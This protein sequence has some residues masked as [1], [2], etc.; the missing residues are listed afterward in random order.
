M[1]YSIKDAFKSLEQLE[2]ETKLA[3][4]SKLT[5]DFKVGDKIKIVNMQGEPQYTGKKGEITHIDDLGQLH[6]TWGGVAIIPEEDD[7]EIIEEDIKDK[8]PQTAKKVDG[9]YEIDDFGKK[10]LLKNYTKKDV[11]KL[12]FKVDEMYEP[13]Y[14]FKTLKFTDKTSNGLDIIKIFRDLHDDRVHVIAYEPEVKDYV[15]G[16][17]YSFDSGS[18]NQGWY[19]F[20]S[21]KDAVKELNRR[22]NVEE[23]TIDEIKDKIEKPLE[24]DTV[25]KGDKWVNKGKEGTHG[26]FKTKKEADAQRKAMFAKK[27]VSEARGVGKGQSL[28]K[29]FKIVNNYN[30]PY[31]QVKEE[32][33]DL[34]LKIK[35]EI[36]RYVPKSAY[37]ERD[38]ENLLNIIEHII[39]ESKYGSSN[40][41]IDI[42]EAKDSKLEKEGIQYFGTKNQFNYDKLQL[43]IDHDNKTYQL[44]AFTHIAKR[45]TVSGPEL[46]RI[47]KRLEDAGYK[48]ISDVEEDLSVSKHMD[49]I[50]FIEKTIKDTKDVLNEE[51]EVVSYFDLDNTLSVIFVWEDGY[52]KNNPN[53]IYS[54]DGEYVLTAGVGVYKEDAGG[55][56]YIIPYNPDSYEVYDDFNAV[57]TDDTPR[58]L[59]N[60]LLQQYNDI[61]NT[62]DVK[63]DGKL[64]PKEVEETEDDKIAYSSIKENKR[65][66]L[67][68]IKKTYLEED[69]ESE[70]KAYLDW[71]KEN[72]K[73]ASNGKVFLDYCQKF[74]IGKSKDSSKEDDLEEGH[75]NSKYSLSEIKDAVEYAFGL[76][77]KERDDYIKNTSTETLDALVDDFKANAKKSFFADSLKKDCKNKVDDTNLSEENNDEKCNDMKSCLDRAVKQLASTKESLNQD[78]KKPLKENIGNYKIILSPRANSRGEFC[79]RVYE[80]LKIDINKSFYTKD[81]N[82]A[83]EQFKQISAKLKQALNEGEHHFKCCICGKEV[84]GWGNN[85]WPVKEEGECCDDCNSNEVIPARIFQIYKNLNP[86][87]EIKEDT[88]TGYI[89]NAKIVDKLPKVGDLYDDNPDHNRQNYYVI[90]INDKGTKDGYRI[91]DIVGQDKEDTDKNLG[92]NIDV[93]HYSVAIKE[94]LKEDKQFSLRDANG[95]E[96]AKNYLNTKKEDELEQ[97]VDVDADNPE[98]LKTSYIGDILLRCRDCRTVKFENPEDVVKDENS[99]STEETQQ[100]TLYNVGEECPHCGSTKGYTIAGQVVVADMNLTQQD[101]ET[102][103]STPTDTAPADSTPT[104]QQVE[105][106][107]STEVEDEIIDD[108]I[109]DSEE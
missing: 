18:W 3:K 73:D 27:R 78:N 93:L 108:E 23:I 16:L 40:E 64:Y 46:R 14:S 67:K 43:R 86:K 49:L 61:I 29:Y 56:Y 71:C 36:I 66:G 19:D 63:K 101:E 89:G 15:V 69:I 22:Y 13:I 30:D 90:K 99:T 103:D 32:D 95:V 10:K 88:S 7:I 4:S 52:E 70:I 94:C 85:P 106:E 35:T 65:V 38:K 21:V 2:E 96:E 28:D 5:E 92:D 104:K 84:D 24:E 105:N 12:G 55:S 72:N 41:R 107:P 68:S 37:E 1:S 81:Y 58:A 82:E 74:N 44:G 57:Y 33:L 60:R 45:Q 51:S 54:Q 98:Q 9:G 31:N 42:K 109:V 75:K 80:N 77:G 76:T 11:E 25:K 26:E 83:L 17:G 6:G 48:K 39:S 100:E 50:D 47:I 87:K 97:V 34:L 62:Y 102:S 91:Y 20:R 59:A 8:E 79:V 53:Y